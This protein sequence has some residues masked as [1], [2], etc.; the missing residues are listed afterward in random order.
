MRN[1]VVIIML[2]VFLSQGVYAEPELKGTASELSQYLAEAP[3]IT[4]LTST[5]E[6]KTPADSAI[7]QIRVMTESATLE[8]A[9]KLNQDMRSM[10]ENRLTA[11]GIS[12]NRIQAQYHGDSASS[13]QR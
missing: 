9:I 8:N 2:V 10:I 1:L 12:K 6:L 11:K 13:E 7:L 3:K 4:I 5:S